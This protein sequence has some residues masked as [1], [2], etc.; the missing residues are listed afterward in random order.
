[1][2]SV[3][4]PSDGPRS[5]CWRFSTHA[6]INPCGDAL[7]GPAPN[8]GPNARPGR[9]PSSQTPK[10]DSSARKE[11]GSAPVNCDCTGSRRGRAL[12]SINA[13]KSWGYQLNGATIEA[14]ANSPYDLLVIDG[15]TGLASGKPFTPDEVERLNAN[16]MAPPHRHFLFLQS[17]K[18]K[19]IGQNTSPRNTWKKK[20]RIG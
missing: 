9:T 19:T 20:R 8:F 12:A 2:A 16:P 17:A 4:R 15:T 18:P 11:C 10:H 14:L 3:G 7:A 13:A 6:N 1:M 5:V